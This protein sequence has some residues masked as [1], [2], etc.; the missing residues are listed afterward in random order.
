MLMKEYL[1]KSPLS[2]FEILRTC[3][4]KQLPS[5]DNFYLSSCYSASYPF[6][7]FKLLA[8]PKGQK[9]L[10]RKD[11]VDL[12]DLSPIPPSG[13]RIYYGHYGFV[14]KEDIKGVL[15]IKTQVRVAVKRIYFQFLSKISGFDQF[16]AMRGLIEQGFHCAEPLL[17]THD[18]FLSKWV[19]GNA[20]NFEGANQ[21]VEDSYFIDEL[22]RAVKRLKD[23]DKWQK[24][25][26]LDVFSNNYFARDLGSANPKDRYT[27]I[28]PIY[29]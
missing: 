5:G 4:P 2:S 20:E 17:A 29:I 10:S 23:S 6:E 28:D 22:L 3:E 24:G 16:I 8:S 12:V 18:H 11:F 21:E 15:G 7:P 13:E 26:R 14:T 27:I 9:Y 1:G 25:W 19:E